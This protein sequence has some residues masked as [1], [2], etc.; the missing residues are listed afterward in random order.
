MLIKLTHV[1]I[2]DTAHPVNLFDGSLE[3]FHGSNL[4]TDAMLSCKKREIMESAVNRHSPYLTG[5]E[6]IVID[7][8]DNE[9]ERRVSLIWPDGDQAI[10]FHSFQYH[11]KTTYSYLYL[12]LFWLPVFNSTSISLRYERQCS[13]TYFMNTEDMAVESPTKVHK[14]KKGT[15]KRVVESKVDD[16][17]AF[18]PLQLFPKT[19]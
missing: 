4:L 17:L 15:P 11:E 3:V 5:V 12:L 2:F 18:T 6:S 19:P 8:I 9:F 1:L 14:I 10:C 13:K 7:K 16:M